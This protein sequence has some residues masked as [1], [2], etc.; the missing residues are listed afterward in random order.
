MSNIGSSNTNG[1]RRNGSRRSHPP[2]PQPPQPEISP[3]QYVFAAATPDPA[4]Y[5]NPNPHP[6][7]EHQKAVNI[8]ND[9]NLKKESLRVEPDEE[10]PG[11]F[12]VSFTFDAT[13]AGSITIMFFAKEGEDCGLT[14][15]KENMLTP[16]TVPFKQGLGQ[17]FRQPC[18]T[19]IDFS[20]FEEA[21]LLKE[22]KMEVYPLAV[23]AEFI[24]VSPSVS[25]DGSPEGGASNSQ[26]T[27][28]VFEKEKGEYQ[29]RV[30][31][32]ILWV[33][34]IRYELQEI[35]WPA[36]PPPLP[37]VEHRKAVRVRNYVNLNKESLR[38]EPDE[39]NLGRFLVSFTFDATVAGSITIMFF[40]K[41]GEDCGLTSTKENMLAPVTVPFDEGLGQK[42]RQPC[43]T[44]ID[45]SMFEETELL[46]VGEMEVYPLAVK[47]EAIPVSPSRSAD[48]NPEGGASNS[49]I[50]ITKAVFEKEKGEYQVRGVKQILWVNGI[51]Y[52]LQDIDRIGN[53]VDNDFDGNDPG[54]ECVICLSEPRDTTVLPCRHRCMC[55]GCAKHL[56]FQT[57]RCP[58]CRR[59]I[60]RLLE[61]KVNTG[62]DN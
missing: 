15:T 62:S 40:A 4:Q 7:V 19:G 26:I 24:P 42:F 59:P 39:E 48:G 54:K 51:R 27:K 18:G 20:M 56:R 6:Y 8:R 23:K 2:P 12:L 46:E 58:T 21:E 44:G 36:I 29:V 17:K 5:Q 28:A 35:N 9:V 41:E 38:V 34:G 47:A 53:S 31:K 30:L 55:S 49:Q 43:G 33:N 45:F 52:V 32:Q 61:I 37:Y 57:N 11:R 25:A 13:A 22:C 14:S 3:N 1:R 16:V 60:V 50:T 10:N